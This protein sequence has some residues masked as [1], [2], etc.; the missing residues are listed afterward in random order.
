[1]LA[2]QNVSIHAVL[3]SLKQILVGTIKKKLEIPKEARTKVSVERMTFRKKI[4]A[5]NKS[6]K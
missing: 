1:M 5:G 3:F 4:A 6:V 2:V